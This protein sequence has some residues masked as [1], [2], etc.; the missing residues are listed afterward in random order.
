MGSSSTSVVYSNLIHLGVCLTFFVVFLAGIGRFIAG[1][2][3][4]LV[5]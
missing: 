5:L 1:N 2:V 3:Q 4:E